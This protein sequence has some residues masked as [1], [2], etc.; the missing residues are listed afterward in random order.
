[1]D[2][3][4]TLTNDFHGTAVVLRPRNGYL[5]RTQVMWA[6]K[7]LCGISDCTCSGP[8]GERGGQAVEAMP[9]GGARIL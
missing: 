2:E 1:M 5:S 6:R 7:K 4:I 3:K 9:D 8:A